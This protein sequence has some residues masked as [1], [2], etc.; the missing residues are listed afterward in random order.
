MNHKAVCNYQGSAKPGEPQPKSPST[1]STTKQPEHDDLLNEID[2]DCIDISTDD[3]A[4][5]MKKGGKADEMPNEQAASKEETSSHTQISCHISGTSLEPLRRLTQLPPAPSLVPNVFR[6]LVTTVTSGNSFWAQVVDD[7]VF[8]R[9]VGTTQQMGKIGEDSL[10]SVTRPFPGLCC[11]TRFSLDGCWYRSRVEQFTK[12]KVEVFFVDYGNKEWKDIQELYHLPSQFSSLPGQARLFTMNSVTMS[13]NMDVQRKLLTFLDGLVSGKTIDAEVVSVVPGCNP[14]VVVCETSSQKTMNEMVKEH[15]IGLESNLNMNPILPPSQPIGPPKSDPVQRKHVEPMTKS[16]DPQSSGLPHEIV[17]PP[18]STPSSPSGFK[19]YM[20]SDVANEMLP[21]EKTFDIFVTEISSPSLFWIQL[22]DTAIDK[23]NLLS[24]LLDV[25]YKDSVFS[26]YVPS[27]GELIVAKFT[28]RLFYRAKVDCIYND[29]TLRVTFVDFGNSEDVYLYDV[30]RIT[31]ELVVIPKLAIKC[32]L[33]GVESS[34][35][36]GGWPVECTNLCKALMLNKRCTA[37]VEGHLRDSVLLRVWGSADPNEPVCVVNDEL[38]M[39]GQAKSAKQELIHKNAELEH[40]ASRDDGFV[41]NG[42]QQ[43]EDHHSGS[44]TRLHLDNRD[45]IVPTEG[46]NVKPQH[47]QRVQTPH[48]VSP[49]PAIGQSPNSA[50]VEHKTP[51][52][53]SQHS[54]FAHST[55]RRTSSE[56]CHSI[57]SSRSQTPEPNYQSSSAPSNQRGRTL[58][59]PNIPC[60]A[61]D[62]VVND[63]ISGGQLYVQM[64]DPQLVRML[65]KCVRELNEFCKNSKQRAAVN[66]EVGSLGCAKFSLDNVWYRAEV[67]SME[68]TGYRVR[69]VDFGNTEVVA[70]DAFLEP[71]EFFYELA[72]LAFRCC[73][74][75]SDESADSWG[76]RS[77][78]VLLK[79]TRNK[80]LSCTAVSTTRSP[81]T[82]KLELCSGG[83]RIDVAKELQKGKHSNG[84]S[85]KRVL[86]EA[87]K[88]M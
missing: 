76:E 45:L 55:S 35:K 38:V 57:F 23:L 44:V 19:T 7:Q 46:K 4:D 80:R 61:F 48:C 37:S 85:S 69:F 49:S 56:S 71:P 28:D 62:I 82:V 1:T 63:V 34:S 27:V 42:K 68:I 53:P 14:E 47:F 15:Q 58:P 39:K 36:A 5:K 12:D 77:K 64:I 51:S 81:Y 52:Y 29:G 74:A 65:H 73:L 33:V 41:E 66:V 24:T 3:V 54:P 22:P 13:Q 70:P 79:I 84:S 67:I 72:P 8:P 10:E 59:L 26:D 86:L 31:Q 30:R 17:S 2:F 88:T 25:S 78:D 83:Q 75:T 50:L 18:P 87:I 60:K 11:L 20:A 40:S 32:G 21:V 43:V 16:Q 9:F 6:L